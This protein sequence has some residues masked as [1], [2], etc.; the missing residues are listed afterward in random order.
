[1]RSCNTRS[2]FTLIELLV[3]IAIIAILAAILLP[4]FAQARERARGA[5]CLSN[6]KQLGMAI[7][8]YNQDYDEHFSGPWIYQDDPTASDVNKLMWFPELLQPYI[9]N[10]QMKR[11][12][13]NTNYIDWASP[14]TYDEPGKYYIGYKWNSIWYWPCLLPNAPQSKHGFTH[15]LA[16]AAVEEPA[17]TILLL[18]GSWPETW[19]DC[20]S[21]AATPDPANGL[22]TIIYKHFDGFN[23]AMGDGHSRYVH[24]RSTKLAQWTIEQD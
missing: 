1:M 23:A 13:S 17:G 12:P 24:K 3:V 6:Q 2:G 8:M 7:M 9:K 19:F 15:F 4:V 18:E 5:S 20:D 14:S 11:C 22:P 10:K 16:D 21:D